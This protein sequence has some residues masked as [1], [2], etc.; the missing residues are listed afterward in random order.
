MKR[1]LSIRVEVEVDVQDEAHARRVGEAMA[2]AAR[3]QV[4]RN[5]RAERVTHSGA[6]LRRR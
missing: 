3:R 4:T 5:L 6:V 2:E 1:T